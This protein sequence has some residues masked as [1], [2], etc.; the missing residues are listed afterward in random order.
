MWV[1]VWLYRD[2]TFPWS[3]GVRRGRGTGR[4]RG[5]GQ[6]AGE[7]GRHH[8][9]AAAVGGLHGATDAAHPVRG[10]L[11]LLAPLAATAR[12]GGGAGRRCRA[13]GR[14]GAGRAETFLLGGGGGF[15]VTASTL[16]SLVRRILPAMSGFGIKGVTPT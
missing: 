4:G 11:L 8:R 12:S 10:L 3:K 15:G 1:R 13:A 6:R 9:P 7:A 2:F 14:R 16:G 5:Q